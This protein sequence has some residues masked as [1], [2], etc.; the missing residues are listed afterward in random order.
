MASGCL[1]LPRKREARDSA[2]GGMDAIPVEAASLARGDSGAMAPGGVRVAV[3]LPLGAAVVEELLAVAV[4][5]NVGG[6]DGDLTA[7]VGIVLT[8]ARRERVDALGDPLE[9]LAELR[10]EAVAGP[11]RGSATEGVREAGMLCDQVSH[12]RPRRQGIERLNEARAEHRAAS[13]PTATRPAKLVKL[14]QQGDHFRRV[15]NRGDLGSDR[16]PCYRRTCQA[17]YTSF[18]QASGG[19]NLAGAI[20][21]GLPCKS[22]V[23]ASDGVAQPCGLRPLRHGSPLCC[24]GTVGIL[25]TA[26]VDRRVHGLRKGFSAQADSE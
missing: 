2:D 7:H 13:V 21:P 19:S 10:R 17:S 18:G 8:Q 15:E 24:P 11:V 23:T 9:F 12:A 25:A 22:L 6:V 20:F 4:G 1:D 16:A 26:G 5:R 3:D 14:A